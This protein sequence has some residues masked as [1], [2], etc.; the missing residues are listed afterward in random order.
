MLILQLEAL[1][2][3]AEEDLAKGKAEGADM[4]SIRAFEDFK[5]KMRRRGDS[6]K[7]R[8]EKLAQRRARSA[9]HGNPL[10]I[11]GF[12]VYVT[13]LFTVVTPEDFGAVSVELPFLQGLT[14]SCVGSHIVSAR[15][16]DF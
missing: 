16:P 8:A 2:K 5:K 12:R 15:S 13:H 11:F 3:A 14:D 9:A 4:P 10:L 6:D 1:A 7:K